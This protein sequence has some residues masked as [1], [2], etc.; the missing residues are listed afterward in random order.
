MVYLSAYYF[1]LKTSL[2][3]KIHSTGVD[4]VVIEVLQLL[5]LFHLDRFVA[6]EEVFE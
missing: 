6:A 4:A 2:P 1:C 3:L 5:L